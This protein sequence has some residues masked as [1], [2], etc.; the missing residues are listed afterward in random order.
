MSANKSFV[1]ESS[2]EDLGPVSQ[3]HWDLYTEEVNSSDFVPATPN[4][5]EADLN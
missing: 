4:N 5:T 3:K 1:A 2:E